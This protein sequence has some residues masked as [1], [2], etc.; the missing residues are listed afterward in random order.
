MLIATIAKR[1][2]I[3]TYVSKYKK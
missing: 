2:N 1:N 3:M